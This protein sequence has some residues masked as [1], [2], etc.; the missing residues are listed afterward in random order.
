MCIYI[1]IERER[2]RDIVIYAYIYIYIPYMF[3]Y[4]YICLHMLISV[5]F[6]IGGGISIR[7]YAKMYPRQ[8]GP[9]P[10]VIYLKLHAWSGAA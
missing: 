5:W 1:Y 8:P 7:T 3:V 4:P 9:R 10:S 2:D 6:G